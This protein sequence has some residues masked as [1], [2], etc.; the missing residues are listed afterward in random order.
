MSVRAILSG[1]VLSAAIATGSAAALDNQAAEK[2]A[3]ERLSAFER[4][5]VSALVA[6]YTDDAV[7]VT[8]A[9]PLNDRAS[10]TAMMEGV[11]AEF[12]QP[13]TRFEVISQA[14][15]GDIFTLVWSGETSKNVY[16]F[17]AET[18]VL[19]DGKI[20]YQTVALKA[21]AK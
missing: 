7:V 14:A 19:K 6:Q 13:G 10:I 21:Q 17:A 8:P 4:G 5:D 2:F 1:A 16:D 20:T 9:G 3:M 18:Y 15:F 12:G 11:I